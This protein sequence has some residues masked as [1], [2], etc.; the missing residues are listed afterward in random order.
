MAL[1]GAQ[2][3]AHYLAIPPSMF[4]TVVEGLAKAG[5]NR[6]SRVIVEK[7]AGSRAQTP[8][9]TAGGRLISYRPTNSALPGPLSRQPSPPME[10]TVSIRRSA[11]WPAFPEAA[12]DVPFRRHRSRSHRP[13]RGVGRPHPRTVRSRWRAPGHRRRHPHRTRRHVAVTQT[14]SPV[15]ATEM[16]L[17]GSR[18]LTI[19][20][21]AG[22]TT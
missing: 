2:R 20:N 10:V 5:L 14:T 22:G 3:V 8:T 15:L 12:Q 9:L 7:R 19:I 13:P 1:S 6:G 16:S 21:S 17:P 4:P 11:R 18:S